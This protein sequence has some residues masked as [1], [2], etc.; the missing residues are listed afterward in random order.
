VPDAI[1]D[2]Q[3]LRKVFRVRRAD[4]RGHEDFVA[5]EDVS[6]AVPPGGS[7][8]IVGE[9]GSGKTTVGRMV[10]GLERASGGTIVVDGEAR[11]AGRVSTGLR[12]AWAR[13]IQMVFQDPYGSL[14]RRQSARDSLEEILRVHGTAKGR[15]LTA[16][17]DALLDQVGL[18][19]RQAKAAPRAL[20]GGQRQ[21]VA[22]A[23]ALAAEPKLMILDEAVA[24][25]DVSIQAQILNL[26]A[27][28][29]EESGTAFLFITHDLAVARHVTDEV[30]VM[31]RGAI[32]E[33][34]AVDDV[35]RAPADAYTQ[36]LIASVP[37]PGWKPRRQSSPERRAIT[38]TS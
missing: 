14:D 26:L 19:E 2:V 33:R 12:R 8:A 20:S 21:R 23:R 28:I 35:L 29:R 38:P 31:H 7:L 11:P 27:Q 25:L 1:V 32:V 36:R 6:F 34:G 13:Q 18:D 22:I 17:I 9:S 15:A 37:R 16:R 10:A 3:S 5:V 4:G 24:A 30:I